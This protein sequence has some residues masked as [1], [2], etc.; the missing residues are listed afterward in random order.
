[1]ADDSLEGPQ[2]QTRDEPADA[3]HVQG[4]SLP[5][6]RLVDT[7]GRF[8]GLGSPRGDS[9]TNN[10]SNLHIASVRGYRVIYTNTHEYEE[11]S[12][13]RNSYVSRLRVVYD[14]RYSCHAV[15]H[16]TLHVCVS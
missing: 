15:P 9:T 10:P 1:M 6:S 2:A 4:G 13:G 16:V 5:V 8:V 11:M 12:G 3:G 7:V 14:N